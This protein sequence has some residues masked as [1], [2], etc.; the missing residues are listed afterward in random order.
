MDINDLLD[1][2]ATTMPSMSI[3][4]PT[5]SMPSMVARNLQSAPSDFSGDLDSMNLNL[6]SHTPFSSTVASVNSQVYTTT[7]T[8]SGLVSQSINKSDFKD[9]I[10][11]NVY[12]DMENSSRSDNFYANELSIKSANPTI[13]P[14]HQ[15]PKPEDAQRLE[16]ER[17]QIRVG[18]K[19]TEEKVEKVDRRE[20]YIGDSDALSY[21]EIYG[22]G[23]ADN[24]GDGDGEESVISGGQGKIKLSVS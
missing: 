3:S 11:S 6:S 14:L 12:D 18:W 15:T 21:D 10:L 5:L 20:D 8:S 2:S 1:P 23:D 4:L 22:Y 24:D 16:K 9:V 19:S 13:N 7:S 17:N